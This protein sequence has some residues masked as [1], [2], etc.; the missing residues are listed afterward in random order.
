MPAE[1][2][3][4]SCCGDKGASV[5]PGPPAPRGP[6]G[7]AVDP[8][9]GSYGSRACGAASGTTCASS[10]RGGPRAR[11]ACLGVVC[12]VGL[13]LVW[14]PPPQGS[15]ETPRGEGGSKGVPGGPGRL[16]IWGA[17][18]RPPA[19][20]RAPWPS[21]ATGGVWGREEGACPLAPAAVSSPRPFRSRRGA[22]S[23]AG[24][25]R[26]GLLERRG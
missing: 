23:Q 21:G 2:A 5:G 8:I 10:I 11:S 17:W 26:L 19:R 15:Q 1:P 16:G 12:E 9:R 24:G 3:S 25:G 20:W 18:L 13:R 22:G 6:G 4:D 7:L 14:E